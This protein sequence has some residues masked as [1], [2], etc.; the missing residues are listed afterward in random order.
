MKTQ[1][2]QLLIQFIILSLLVC[3]LASCGS[4]PKKTTHDLELRISTTTD[5]NP[6]V[7]SRPSPIVLHVL[8][9]TDVD[10]FYRAEYLSLARDDASALGGDV[11]NKSEV[12][13]KPGDSRET[14]LEL[15]Q[16]T[17][18][19]GFVAGY[20]D[21]EHALWRISQEIVP[22]KTDWISVKLSE[23]QILIIEVND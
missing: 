8:Q 19:L 20:R 13:L 18:Y 5:V 9:L 3:G 12:V 2:H 17:A 11:L 16:Q 6:D 14:V 10:E 1:I 23:K 22:G 4:A 21:I 7:E 15:N